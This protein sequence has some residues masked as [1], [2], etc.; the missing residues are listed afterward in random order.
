MQS[1]FPQI[2]PPIPNGLQL[3]QTITSTGSVTIPSSVTF[4]YAIVIGGG[5]AGGNGNTGGGGAGGIQMGWCP[6]TNYA[7]VGVGGSPTA[8][9][10]TGTYYMGGH[11]IYSTI[12][13]GGGAGYTGGVAT[14]GGAGAGISSGTQSYGT[15]G[16]TGTSA[17][18]TT[19]LTYG[20][21]SNGQVSANAV[22]NINAY[23]S[24][25]GGVGKTGS[26]AGVNGGNG[27]IGG[28]GGASA[29]GTGGNGGNGVY[30]GAAGSSSTHGGGGGGGYLAAGPGSTGGP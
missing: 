7:I 12:A 20:R 19:G 10:G 6:A 18:I 28:G 15:E 4:V 3:R 27:L 29:S 11:S 2:I 5:G 8:V 13:A 22:A 9:S 24:G 26:T 17:V 14:N 30:A 21:W 25:G 16:I 23:G 1:N